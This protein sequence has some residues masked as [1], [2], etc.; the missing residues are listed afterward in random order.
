MIRKLLFICALA[1]ASPGLSQV[2]TNAGQAAVGV[3][4][5][6]AGG[7]AS[8]CYVPAQVPTST[9]GAPF[10]S[11]AQFWNEYVGSGTLLAAGQ[12][13]FTPARDAGPYVNVPTTW[14]FFNAW[15]DTVVPGTM[16]IQSSVDNISWNTA[17][18]TSCAVSTPTYARVPVM[19]RYYRV[20]YINSASAQAGY[21]NLA[22][23]F[24]RN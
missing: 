6:D 14:G 21:F 12:S 23:S 10:A 1:L 11:G 2:V 19:S 24:S 4:C 9:S 15:C 13:V 18:T 7:N 8:T 17:Q 5:T 22:V 20:N 16:Y 3:V